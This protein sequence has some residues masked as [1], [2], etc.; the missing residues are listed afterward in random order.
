MPQTS[1]T[2]DSVTVE[3]EEPTA[4]DLPPVETHLR[5]CTA[6][7]VVDDLITCDHFRNAVADTSSGAFLWL[8]AQLFTPF[9]PEDATPSPEDVL[10]DD[11]VADNLR[12]SILATLL[13]REEE[14]ESPHHPLSV[15]RLLSAGIDDDD[16]LMLMQHI[17]FAY[18]LYDLVKF[19]PTACN[20]VRKYAIAHLEEDD[21]P[22]TTFGF[23]IQDIAAARHEALLLQ[24]LTKLD[25]LPPPG[26]KLIVLA[27]CYRQHWERGFLWLRSKVSVREDLL[28][29]VN[30][31]T[32]LLAGGCVCRAKMNAYICRILPQLTSV[33]CNLSCGYCAAKSVPEPSGKASRKRRSPAK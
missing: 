17:H 10:L 4:L 29:Q 5:D 3:G 25:L 19:A 9:M 15:F 16:H 18:G 27:E 22:L 32:A 1:E 20:R 12:R 24:A 7:C 21:E 8:K 13:D 26:G 33:Q 28:G 23:L 2:V 6:A 30:Y 11:V 14:Q 31:F